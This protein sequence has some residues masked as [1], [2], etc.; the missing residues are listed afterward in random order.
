[1]PRQPQ[2]PAAAHAQMRRPHAPNEEV[3]R[4]P[5]PNISDRLKN[6][7]SISDVKSMLNSAFNRDM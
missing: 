2:Q 6:A 7:Q 1:M 4:A 5:K 3:N